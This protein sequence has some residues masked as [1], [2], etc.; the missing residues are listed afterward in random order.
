[1]KMTLLNG[2]VIM[3]KTSVLVLLVLA[4]SACMQENAADPVLATD[5][6]E[7]D[8]TLRIAAAAN[9]FDVLPEIVDGYQT[10][11][12]LAEKNIEVTFASS[13]KL[14]AQIKAGAPYDVYLSANQAF[15]AKLAGEHL[16]DLS[17][18]KSF[19]YARGQL[20]LYSVTR[21]LGDMQPAALT[22]LLMSDTSTKIAIANPELAPYGASAKS[23]LQAQNVNDVL[24]EQKRLIQAENIGQAF[25]YTHT[26]NVDYGL[27][28]QSQVGAIKATPE[29]FV[30]LDP[31]SYPA[32]LQ[33]GVVIK[34]SSMATDFTD[35]IR[36]DAGQKY[37]SQAGY[38][39]IQ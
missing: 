9:L 10:E 38:L 28:A 3:V 39:S 37:F 25:Q 16:P 27:V 15:P 13:G 24:D 23:Y 26:G 29:Q 1:M 20:T 17:V 31:D 36:S 8:Q 19:S 4:L 33:D 11:N 5:T 30:T 32:I 2:S 21:P 35:Y 7:Q 18:H 22:A 34:D 12:N 6:A 14:Y